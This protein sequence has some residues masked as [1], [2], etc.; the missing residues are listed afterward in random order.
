[1]TSP[2]GSG[3]I[4]PMRTR[5]STLRYALFA[6]ALGV[7][8][9]FGAAAVEPL[10]VSHAAAAASEEIVV[11]TELEATEVVQIGRAEIAKGSKVNVT[12]VEGSKD[13]PSSVDLALADGQV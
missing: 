7:C 2:G 12:K 3:G 13:D 10:V 5:V 1:M 6:A 11:G 8:S 9:G 4:V